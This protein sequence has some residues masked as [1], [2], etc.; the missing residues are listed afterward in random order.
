MYGVHYTTHLITFHIAMGTVCVCVYIRSPHNKNTHS[1]FAFISACLHSLFFSYA[2]CIMEIYAMHGAFYCAYSSFCSWVLFRHW[3]PLLL[4]YSNHSLY[5]CTWL[6][7]SFHL[8]F[9]VPSFS[10]ARF[11]FRPLSLL[12][13]CIFVLFCFHLVYVVHDALFLSPCLCM[14]VYVCDA[15][16][17][18]TLFLSLSS[19]FMSVFMRV[20]H[21]F[22]IFVRLSMDAITTSYVLIVLGVGWNQHIVFSLNWTVK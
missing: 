13:S 17:S 8:L 6:A 19:S 21:M 20:L 14:S 1:V 5:I 12:S 3:N 22:Y 15:L 2:R 18:L 11:L 9:V 7:A 16:V 10:L 4:C